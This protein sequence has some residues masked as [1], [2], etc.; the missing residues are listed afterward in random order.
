MC[1]LEEPSSLPSLE[2]GKGSYSCHPLMSSPVYLLSPQGAS[3]GSVWRGFS[4]PRVTM[5]NNWYHVTGTWPVDLLTSWLLFENLAPG[6]NSCATPKSMLA[7][8]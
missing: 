1:F 8:P 5:A 2:A 6:L 3:P 4:F 7:A